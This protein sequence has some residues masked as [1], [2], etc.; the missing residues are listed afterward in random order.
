[1]RDTERETKMGRETE[2]LPDGFPSLYSIRLDYTSCLG[3]REVAL[4]KLKINST[5]FLCWFG[6]DFCYSQTQEPDSPSR[7]LHGPSCGG[8]RVR[9]SGHHVNA[10]AEVSKE[11]L[12]IFSKLCI[13]ANIHHGAENE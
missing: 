9:V 1:M 13:T 4:L 10:H 2:W 6:V 3:F 5:F 8:Q 11:G 7:R 12:N